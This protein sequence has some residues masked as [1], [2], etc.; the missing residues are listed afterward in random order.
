MLNRRITRA[1]LDG[2]EK[3][4][5]LSSL[6]SS[7]LTIALTTSS[8]FYIGFHEKFAA[9]YFK[10]KTP[11][12]T[13]ATL[14]VKYWDGSAWSAVDDLIDQTSSGGKVFAQSGFISWENKADWKK[15]ALA[16]IDSDVEMY[17]VKLEVS[18][19]ILNTTEL[20]AVINLF[21]DDVGLR[22]L[23]PEIVIDSRFLPSGRTDF[24]EQHVSAKD[25][26][27]LKL[28][29]RKLITDESQI[30]DI[31]QV[32]NA[33]VHACAAIILH[34][35]ASSD[36]TRELLARAEKARDAELASTYLSVDQ[37]KDGVISEAERSS[38]SVTKVLRR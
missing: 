2:S 23:Y 15:V 31:N 28:K 1:V 24:L 25:Y 22:A 18:A 4:D 11:N 7:A 37:N 38:L 19:T 35:I 33:A 20:E 21:S 14:A 13:A 8:A 34:P 12:T 16:P 27:V 6:N 5:F 29:Q 30:V 17:W 9:R 36:E 32:W 26:V 3:T 10:V